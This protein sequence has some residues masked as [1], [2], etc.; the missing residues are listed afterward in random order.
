[1]LGLAAIWA[2]HGGLVTELDNKFAFLHAAVLLSGIGDALLIA[3]LIGALVD[4]R[5]KRELATE[6]AS[7]TSRMTADVFYRDFLGGEYLPSEYLE[8]IKRLAKTDRLSLGS[9]W[10]LRLDWADSDKKLVKVTSSIRNTIKNVDREGVKPSKPWLLCLTDGR[11]KS[12][13]TRYEVELVTSSH[14]VSQTDKITRWVY[15]DLGQLSGKTTPEGSGVRL[16]VEPHEV[17]IIPPG[18]HLKTTLEGVTFHDSCGLMPL[19]CTF[20]TLGQELK[21]HGDAIG[22]LVVS[23]RLGTQ[24]LT[25]AS[26]DAD[27]EANVLYFQSDLL[28]VRGSVLLVQWQPKPPVPRQNRDPDRL[29]D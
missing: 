15:E 17:C 10:V 19:M 18:E 3:T 29:H 4:P 11:P 9:S 12:Y 27:G 2:S 13:F 20:S 25:S 1:V 23:V 26:S 14:E 22:D 7:Q 5:L 8:G 16:N 6:I 21:V 24:I 28:A